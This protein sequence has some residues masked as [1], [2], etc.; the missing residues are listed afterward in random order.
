[1]S[2]LTLE[3]MSV[4]ESAGGSGMGCDIAPISSDMT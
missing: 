1:M 2:P 3:P 4:I